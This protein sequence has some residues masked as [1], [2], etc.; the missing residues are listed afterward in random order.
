MIVA[1]FRGEW[2]T[3]REHF[4][5]SLDG[6]LPVVGGVG[7]HKTELEEPLPRPHTK[8]GYLLRHSS[9]SQ[10]LIG[11]ETENGPRWDLQNSLAR[12]LVLPLVSA[13]ASGAASRI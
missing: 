8:F 12:I 3:Y 6:A 7:H 9:L 4:L 2:K 11:G 10:S 5:G 13:P 1:G